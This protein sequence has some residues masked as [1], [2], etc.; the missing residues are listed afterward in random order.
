MNK[1][2][3]YK[4]LNDHN[5]GIYKLESTTI[6]III[7]QILTKLGYDIWNIDKF[8][9]FKYDGELVFYIHKPSNK[10]YIEDTMHPL[11]SEELK[12]IAQLMELL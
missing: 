4:M 12:L 3:L 7:Q 11:G 8:I 1:Q 6:N 9:E 10:L 2:E 5:A